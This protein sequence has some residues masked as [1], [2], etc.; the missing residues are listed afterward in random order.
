MSNLPDV[1][2]R[3]QPRWKIRIRTQSPLYRGRYLATILAVEEE[4]L[5]I[6]MPMEGGQVV[7]LP[8]G[9]ELKIEVQE[10]GAVT[11]FP[12]LVLQRQG[13]TDPY[14]VLAHPKKLVTRQARGGWEKTKVLA[15][16][17]GKGGVGKS[18]LALNLAVA[19]GLMGRRVCL[20]DGDFGMANLHILLN[21]QSPY[22]LGHLWNGER[23]I[24]DLLCPGP[25]GIQVLPGLTGTPAGGYLGQE[26]ID[27]LGRGLLALDGQFD[28]VIIDTG[29][30]IDVSLLTLMSY[31]TR[32]ILVTT[33]EPHAITD[34]YTMIKVLNAWGYGGP[35]QLLVN[36]VDGERDGQE[37]AGKI[38]FAA[39]QFLDY[40]L[41]YIGCL[42]LDPYV[43]RAVRRQ[44]DL[45]TAYPSCRAAQALQS[46]AQNIGGEDT[47]EVPSLLAKLSRPLRRWGK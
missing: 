40:N 21:L 45:L 7:L 31:V 39:R 46:L 43:L 28:Y 4:T 16:I 42:P 9:T 5:R 22:N 11:S 15:F 19:L 37:T 23:T 33:P 27:L 3:L 14:L 41:D 29:S 30:R 10:P 32:G 44:V 1:F 20:I 17:S 34:L 6:S 35:L 26:Q 18:V 13:G 38:I 25:G 24:T 36:M 12:S 2:D 8:V 47:A